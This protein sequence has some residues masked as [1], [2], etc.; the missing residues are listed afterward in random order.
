MRYVLLINIDKS[1]PRQRAEMEAI[2]HGH[3]RFQAPVAG[4]ARPVTSGSKP[5]G[6]S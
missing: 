4:M 5:D 1:A 3:E 6:G 2:L